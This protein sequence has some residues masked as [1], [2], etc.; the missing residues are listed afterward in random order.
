[1][2]VLKKAC[3]GNGET[4]EK[5]LLSSDGGSISSRG[6]ETGAGLKGSK[7]VRLSDLRPVGMREREEAARLL[8]WELR[9]W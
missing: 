5:A 2:S 8:A 1:M 9:G 7:E 6:D 3:G 4:N